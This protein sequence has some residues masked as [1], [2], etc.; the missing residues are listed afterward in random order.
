MKAITILKVRIHVIMQA[1]CVI[2]CMYFQ[3]IENSLRGWH[4]LYQARL[5][6]EALHDTTAGLTHCAL[7]RIWKQNVEDVER[8]FGLPLIQ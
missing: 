7:P 8:L 5:F 6:E 4:I 3:Q 1:G 2:I